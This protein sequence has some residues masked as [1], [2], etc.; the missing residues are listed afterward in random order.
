MLTTIALL[1]ALHTIPDPPKSTGVDSS[2]VKYARAAWAAIGRKSV[3]SMSGLDWDSGGSGWSAQPN[4]K[5]ADNAGQAAYEIEPLM[6]QLLALSQ[7]TNDVNGFNEAARFYNAYEVRFTTVGDILADAQREGSKSRA[8]PQGDASAKTLRWKDVRSSTVSWP[9][10]CNLCNAQ[11]FHPAARLI[12]LIAELPA[13]SRTPSMQSFVKDYA[14]LIAKDHL[15]RIG[16]DTRFPQYVKGAPDDHLVVLWEQAAKGEVKY[17]YLDRDLWLIGAAAELLEANRIDQALVNLPADQKQKL[18]RLLT[19]GTKLLAVNRKHHPDVKNLQGKVVGSDGYF[20]GAMADHPDQTYSGDTGPDYPAGKPPKPSPT[21]SWDVSHLQRLPVVLRSLWDARQTMRDLKV[22]FPDSNDIV[23]ATNQLTYKVFNGNFSRPQLTNYFDGSDGWYRVGYKSRDG[24]GNPPSQYC[25][26]QDMKHF[27]LTRN[28]IR[29]WGVLAFA[30][31]D[32]G[33]LI[34]GVIA[35][36]KD[37][38]ADATKFRQRV[39]AMK[40]DPSQWLSDPPQKYSQ[41]LSLLI[42][43]Y[44]LGTTP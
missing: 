28:G 39:I 15:I 20:E 34:E 41:E 44:A 29:G 3:S 36:A 6:R 43:E 22:A 31:A 1:A 40:D 8:M 2:W 21:V 37:S 7:A 19:A 12:H 27:C 26:G 18:A 13:A 10:E 25:D 5:N 16:F 30:N 11:F 33:K 14:P 38:S 4:Y 35:V 23:Q 17:R 24:Y 32:L 9:A 42:A